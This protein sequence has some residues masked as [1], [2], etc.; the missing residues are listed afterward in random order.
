[1]EEGG[2]RRTE[3]PGLMVEDLRFWSRVGGS[4]WT[5]GSGLSGLCSEAKIRSCRTNLDL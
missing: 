4:G 2:T 1:M 3:T 5:E